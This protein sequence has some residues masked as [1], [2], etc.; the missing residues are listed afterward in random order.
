MKAY[1]LIFTGIAAAFAAMSCTGIRKENIIDP[2][3][4]VHHDDFEYAVVDYKKTRELKLKDETVTANGVFYIVTFKVKNKALRGDHAWDNR[5]AYLI[6]DDSSTYENNVALQKKMNDSASFGFKEEYVTP[7]HSEETTQ[8][9]FDMPVT[10]EKPYLKVR[11]KI[12]LVDFL[13]GSQFEETK[14][15]LF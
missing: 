3:M 8:L 10:T 2:G 15:K 13:D 6:A 9:I 14:V 1:L 5:I 11:G 12:L 4:P 7:F